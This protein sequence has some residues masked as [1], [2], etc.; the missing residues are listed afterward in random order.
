MWRGTTSEDRFHANY[1]ME[2]NSG[3]WLWAGACFQETGYGQIKING[4]KIGTHRFS[5]LIHR[6]PIPSGM[7]VCHH[8][9]TP[10]CVNPEHLFLG[11]VK[12]NSQDCIKKDRR[13][14][15]TIVKGEN[16]PRAKLTSQ[17]VM[18]IRASG[19]T[20]AVLSGLYGVDDSVVARIRTREAWKHLWE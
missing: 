1:I 4:K 10:P 6:G 12:D 13:P 11:T 17:Q 20:C 16:H 18:E 7:L 15:T 14:K 3:C 8:C 5:W 9:D 19:L 2:P